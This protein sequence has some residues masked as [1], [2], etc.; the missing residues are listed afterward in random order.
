MKKNKTYQF[1]SFGAVSLA[2]ILLINT[3][4]V[5]AATI[6]VV[7][8]GDA[9]PS[10]N[11]TN[12]ADDNLRS[13]ICYAN[14]T[15]GDHTITLPAG[16]YTLSRTGS[17]E[18]A[19][20]TGDL[21]INL[22]SG[23]TLTINGASAASTII[24]AND[25]DRVFHI[26]SGTVVI[27]NVTIT[28]GTAPTGTG[29][30]GGGGIYIAGS[31]VLTLNNCVLSDNTANVDNGATGG[32]GGALE[33]NGGAVTIN[34]STFSGNT[35]VR[36]GA[37]YVNSGKV[38]TVTKSIFSGNTASGSGGGL[39][40]IGTSTITES[41]FT[42]NSATL[43]GGGLHNYSGGQITLTNSTLS[44]NTSVNGGGVRNYDGTLTF[45]HCT[46]SG[47]TATTGSGGGILRVAGTVNLSNSIVANN[48]AATGPDC[49]GT[50][51]SGGYNLIE[52]TT[53]CTVSATNNIIGSDPSLA[54][55][56]NNGGPTQTHALNEGS[57]AID[58]IPNGTSGCGSTYTTDQRGSSYTRPSPDGGACDI[59]AYEYQET[60]GGALTFSVS[61]T[62]FAESGSITAAIV[63]PDNPATA[64]I[65][66][67]S[68]TSPTSGAKLLLCPTAAACSPGTS[69]TVTIAAN[70][71]TSPTFYVLGVN[72]TTED[73]SQAV[74]LTADSTTASDPNDLYASGTQDVTVTDDD[75]IVK[76]LTMTVQPARITEGGTATV[77]VKLSDAINGVSVTLASGSSADLTIGGGGSQIVSSASGGTAT[78]TI[79][80][81]ADTTDEGLEKVILT[82]TAS[83]YTTATAEVFIRDGG[84]MSGD[85][86]TFPSFVLHASYDWL[87]NF[88]DNNQ[89]AIPSSTSALKKYATDNFNK[90]IMIDSNLFPIYTALQGDFEMPNVTMRNWTSGT[91]I[92]SPSANDYMNRSVAAAADYINVTSKIFFGYGSTDALA[93]VGMRSYMQ[94]VY[95]L[96]PANHNFRRYKFIKIAD[97]GIPPYLENG[98]PE[99]DVALAPITVNQANVGDCPECDVCHWYAGPTEEVLCGAGQGVENECC[100]K[101]KSSTSNAGGCEDNKTTCNDSCYDDDQIWVFLAKRPGQG[102]TYGSNTVAGG[103]AVD[104]PACS[105]A[106]FPPAHNV[107]YKDT[108]K[109]QGA[110]YF[111][112]PV[113]VKKEN[114]SGNNVTVRVELTGFSHDSVS[115]L[116]LELNRGISGCEA[117]AVIAANA[118]F[119]SASDTSGDYIAQPKDFGDLSPNGGSCDTCQLKAYQ[120]FTIPL[121]CAK[122][123]QYSGAYDYMYVDIYP[124]AG[125][126]IVLQVPGMPEPKDNAF[127]IP[128][129]GLDDVDTS[130]M[131]QDQINTLIAN[132]WANLGGYLDVVPPK[133]Y[134]GYVNYTSRVGY[135]YQTNTTFNSADNVRF[136]DPRDIAVYR[137]YFDQANGGPVYIFVADTSNSR[138]QVFMNATGSAG[139][140]GAAFPIRPVRVKGPNDTSAKTYYKSNELGM[141]IYSSNG[142]SVR[143]GDGRKADWRQ[144]TTLPGTSFVNISAGKGEFFY[145]HSIAVDQDPDTKDVYLFVADTFNHRIQVFRDV[146]GV[147][148][149]AITAKK[150]DFE[151]EAG[152]GTYPLQTSE[153]VTNPGAYNFRYPKGLSVARFKENSSLLYVVD[154][155]NYRM[156]KYEIGENGGGG[157]SGIVAANGYGYNGSKFVK[158]LLTN[159]GQPLTAHNT[160]PGF[161]NPQDVATGYSGFFNYTSPHGK[162]TKFLNNYM[163]YVT[164]YARNM[165]TIARDRLNMR[166]MQFIEVPGVYKSISGAWIP[167][168]TQNYTTFT[169]GVLGQSVYGI[170]DG[171]YNSTG[172]S[173]AATKS[174]GSS[175]N[176]P[177]RSA[178]FTDRPV[179]ITTL[180][181]N[182]LKPI[183]IRVIKA[184]GTETKTYIPGEALPLNESLRIG[185]SSRKLSFGYP[186]NKKIMF[187]GYSTEWTELTGRW[188]ATDAGRVHLFCYDKAGKYINGSHNHLN[189]VL[190]PSTTTSITPYI[191]R[192]SDLGCTSPGFVKI[193]VEDEDFG[194]DARTGTAFYGVQ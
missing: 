67:V 18:D 88:Y 158:N 159:A 15:A 165:T 85:T 58:V 107:P 71:T 2:F 46:I 81:V 173:A 177:G 161:W 122:E 73:G 68:I 91:G 175:G 148:S 176:V 10:C 103:S 119:T 12:Q 14:A 93:A 25:L 140:P 154:S 115:G 167:W 61:S 116:A 11:N 182:T 39:Y 145:P 63:R 94:W 79:L 187:T 17:S 147:S 20:S 193:V 95:A 27:N 123:D 48:S 47:N 53:G 59:G 3:A 28:D 138:I 121:S 37:I 102:C 160:T 111:R 146:S 104:M 26:L 120:D 83:G 149:Q 31:S 24:D 80:A 118:N 1:L 166:V 86:L 189:G 52:S 108:G 6:S 168:A 8:N 153:F 5:Q 110:P 124:C 57:P 156:M 75:G 76:A 84:A 74:T 36:G 113:A 169:K 82:A 23:K 181:W 186:E 191:V 126:G 96:D 180:H 183:D 171:V 16:T 178:Y 105:A 7:G 144:Y 98:I 194:F 65:V 89:D 54:A 152:W 101:P 142:D 174:A 179:G 112:I 132:R 40:N 133:S 13:A 72:N 99:G 172:S 134:P 33:N 190:E 117:E 19:N 60:P 188:D 129:A 77:T 125:A 164:D 184:S 44:G 87:H 135:G 163:V 50:V 128:I 150:F 90:L 55:L 106:N 64:L 35:A 143:F 141:R 136:K 109:P 21:D 127:R 56:A 70:S 78:F 38:V 114:I 139:E 49:S 29:R 151:F 4:G 97:V 51:T 155:K 41:L 137:D 30:R 22:G 192:L 34:S 62:S 157:I 66:T 131:T 32:G 185:I 69:I 130:G 162:G 43:T 92:Y 100:D 42:N 170:T 45:T 9:A